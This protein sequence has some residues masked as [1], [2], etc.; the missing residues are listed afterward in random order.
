MH[1]D[2]TLTHTVR[3]PFADAEALREYAERHA[4][5][6][7]SETIRQAVAEVIARDTRRSARRQ[8][9]EA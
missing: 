1:P 4:R 8:R 6:N 7:I 5:G 9:E 2:K 3:F